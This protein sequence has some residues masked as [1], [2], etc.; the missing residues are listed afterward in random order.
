MTT[1][2]PERTSHDL[3]PSASRAKDAATARP[4]RRATP[5][6][7]GEQSESR[8]YD[9]LG[10][11]DC[12]GSPSQRLL[13]MLAACNII[14]EF[15]NP[16]RHTVGSYDK[17]A[18]QMHIALGHAAGRVAEQTG[19]R[20]FGKAEVASDTGEGVPENM[21]R[22]VLSF[23][24]AQTRS[25]TRTTPTKCPSP[26]S[27]GKTRANLL[28]PAAAFDAGDRGLSENPDLRAALGVGKAD[29]MSP[30]D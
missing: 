7:F 10:R 18:I 8:A 21:W 30:L 20:Q 19:D 1:L 13:A 5:R 17:G 16:L 15:R 28:R 9:A 4:K 24:F 26:Q 22:H 3:A 27:A 6:R 2:S 23:A 14:Q 25:S 12:G 29:A 11:E